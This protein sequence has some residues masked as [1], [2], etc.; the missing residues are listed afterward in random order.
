MFGRGGV[1]EGL[2]RIWFLPEEKKEGRGQVGFTGYLE[3]KGKVGTY[4]R[5]KEG[6]EVCPYH[7]EEQKGDGG[8]LV[9]ARGIRG[10]FG[11]YHAEE[12][13]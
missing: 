12:W 9:N 8:R 1:T 10:E 5:N 7:K 3:E 2:G 13:G 4:Y 6:G 11:P